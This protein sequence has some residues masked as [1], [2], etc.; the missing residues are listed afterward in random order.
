MTNKPD[1]WMPLVIRDYLADTGHLSTAE[2]GAYLLLL[3]AAWTRG[4]TLPD[5]DAQ[6]ARIT[7]ASSREWKKLRASLAPYFHVADGEWRQKRLLKELAAANAAVA[8]AGARAAKGANARWQKVPPDDGPDPP[9]DPGSDALSIAQA[10]REEMRKQS[11]GNAPTPIP[12][13]PTLRSGEGTRARVAGSPIDPDFG[14]SEAVRRWAEKRD[15]GDLTPYLEIFV[16]RNRASGRVYKDWDQAFMNAI[17]EDWYGL[18]KATAAG[19][20]APTLTEKRVA[21]MDAICGR[22]GNG[23][24]LE[25]AASR[26]DAAAV[27]AL[28]GNLRQ[29]GD[30]DVGRR[31]PIRAAAGLG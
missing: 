17:R 20:R 15:Y 30:D 19:N 28:P 12:P 23:R 22:S 7:R 18:R 8:M 2:H 29:P 4:G 16:G 10:L 9:T 27:L 1:V 25:G 31:E 14:V 6:L 21:N 26:V 11:L 3:M 13:S 5:D 24:D